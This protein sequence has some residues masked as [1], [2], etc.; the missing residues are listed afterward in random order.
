MTY[1]LEELLQRVEK[2]PVVATYT[3]QQE[4]AFKRIQSWIRV[5]ERSTHECFTRLKDEGFSKHDATSAIGR[6]VKCGLLDNKRYAD[7]L[8]RT[9][10]R[11]GRGLYSIEQELSILGMQFEDVLDY[12]HDLV[13]QC[14]EPELERAYQ[15]LEKHPIRAK[16]KQSAAFR[17]LVGKGF[18]RDIAL[19]ASR[20]FVQ[21]MYP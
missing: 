17:R 20:N 9:R 8:V 11:Q 10:F 2:E 13:Q 6:A 19:Q 15:V 14:C 3:Q 5:R 12:S 1:T 16:H 18:S 7:A 21:N 4:K